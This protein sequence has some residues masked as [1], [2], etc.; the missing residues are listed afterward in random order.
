MK[1]QGQESRRR[2]RARQPAL[3][4]A[5]SRTRRRRANGH[6][7]E[8]DD[9]EGPHGSCQPSRRSSDSP[10]SRWPRPAL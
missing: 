6:G 3:L 9:G 8:A 4:G 7:A 1:H 2:A 5:W 10:R